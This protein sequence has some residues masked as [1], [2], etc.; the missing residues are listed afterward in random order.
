MTY[1]KDIGI[2]PDIVTDNGIKELKV[3]LDKIPI[4]QPSELLREKE[5][6]YFIITLTDLKHINQVRTQLLL[7]GVVDFAI[8]SHELIFD[9]DQANHSGLKGAFIKAF[10][11]IYKEVDFAENN[12]NE[13]LY[14]FKN[15]IKWWCD[16]TEWLLERYEGCRNISLLDVGPGVGIASLIYK[17][18]LGVSL[19][20][21]NLREVRKEHLVTKQKN[22]LERENINIKYGCIEFDEFEGSYDIII[23]T[24]IIEHLACNPVNTMKKLYNMLKP[25]GHLVLTAV[26]K[27]REGRKSPKYYLSWRD[28]PS[29]LNIGEEVLRITMTEHVYD[30]SLEE[31]TDILSET[32]FK[33]IYQKLHSKIVCICEKA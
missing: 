32:G 33:I 13:A 8:L 11:S 18:L 25:N 2:G 10:N 27:N 24:D 14:N 3:F 9:F 22:F 23:F 31:I 4:M 6:Y 28:M 17:E 26:N 29:P 12:F 21:I 20:W 15:P 7:W 30:Y 19:N 1:L 16:T 5:N